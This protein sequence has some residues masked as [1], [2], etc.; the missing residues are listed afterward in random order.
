[1]V[2]D[3]AGSHMLVSTPPEVHFTWDTTAYNSNETVYLGDED[4]TLVIDK[5]SF[6]PD[7]NGYTATIVAKG[8][9]RIDASNGTNWF[10]DTN[11]TL[12][13]IAGKDIRRTTTGFMLASSENCAFHFYAGHDI[14]MRDMAWKAAGVHEFYG[15]FTAG[16][17]VYF[18]SPYTLWQWT[19]FKW[20]RWGLDPVG[21]TPSFTVQSWREI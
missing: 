13:I 17:R 16:N 14:E 2:D 9:V 20:S 19:T 18:E 1:M 6:P 11:Q 12:N 3:V 15:S 21:W 10:V 4:C 8:D 5:V 7:A